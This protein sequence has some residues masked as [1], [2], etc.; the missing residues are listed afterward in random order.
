MAVNSPTS[1]ADLEDALD[2]LLQQAYRNGVNVD[3]GGYAL[4]HE[5]DTIPDWDLTVIRME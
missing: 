1:K 5:D 3:N 2:V 4:V